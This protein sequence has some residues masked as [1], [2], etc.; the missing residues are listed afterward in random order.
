MI[1]ISVQ[2]IT[3]NEYDITYIEEWGIIIIYL[4]NILNNGRNVDVV[5]CY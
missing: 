1:V 4:D 2:I 3:N 5:F